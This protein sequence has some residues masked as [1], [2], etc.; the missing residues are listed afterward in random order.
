MRASCFFTVSTDTVSARAIADARGGPLR[1]DAIRRRLEGVTPKVLTAT[2]RR[3]EQHGLVTRTVYPAVPLHV[4]YELTALGR[5]L[6]GPLAAI[7]A[8]AEE[9]LDDMPMPER[10]GR[11]GS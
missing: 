5:T 2:L 7:R 6:T 10:G 3:L 11:D 1:F 4:E 8:W 9:H